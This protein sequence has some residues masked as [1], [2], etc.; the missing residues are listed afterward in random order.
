M[1]KL[2]KALLKYIVL[3]TPKLTP[4]EPFVHGSSSSHA[5]A[6][7]VRSLTAEEL[8]QVLGAREILVQTRNLEELS[9]ALAEINRI[10][11]NNP[12]SPFLPGLRKLSTLGKNDA[13]LYRWNEFYNRDSKESCSLKPEVLSDPK[14]L[15]ELLIVSRY[16]YTK[17]LCDVH[18]GSHLC[19]AY[20][21]Y[22]NVKGGLYQSYSNIGILSD[23]LSVISEG[24]KLK[25]R[26]EELKQK[27]LEKSLKKKEEE[28]AIEYARTVIEQAFSGLFNG[29][30]II[31]EAKM[32]R[33]ASTLLGRWILDLRSSNLETVEPSGVFKMTNL[34]LGEVWFCIV[35]DK[36]S[37]AY[38]HI[39]SFSKAE[40]GRYLYK[41]MTKN[42]MFTPQGVVVKF[43][44]DREKV[45]TNYTFGANDFRLQSDE[46][47]QLLPGKHGGV[48]TPFMLMKSTG[49]S[50]PIATDINSTSSIGNFTIVGKKEVLVGS[51]EV[52]VEGEFVLL[53]EEQCFNTLIIGNAVFV[54]KDGRDFTYTQPDGVEFYINIP[55]QD[56]GIKFASKSSFKDYR[57]GIEARF[58]YSQITQSAQM[59]IRLTAYDVTVLRDEDAEYDLSFYHVLEMIYND[60]N[61]GINIVTVDK[62]FNFEEYFALFIKNNPAQAEAISASLQDLCDISKCYFELLFQNQ[63]DKYPWLLSSNTPE[64]EFKISNINSN[65]SLLFNANN[66][67]AYFSIE[68]GRLVLNVLN[69][70]GEAR[71]LV[72]DS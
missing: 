63:D 17:F 67:Q 55:N 39:H 68:G 5:E 15:A 43:F 21:N 34:L 13:F 3:V 32:I 22:F 47:Y 11:A 71:K 46:D 61:E 58:S 62:L 27:E 53:K 65:G 33:I 16:E 64:I 10:L 37:S 41:D 24:R 18:L 57:E 23:L 66:L 70:N 45:F 36:A 51:T 14:K 49:L 72:F 25:K 1:K 2:S 28:L 20:G 8:K 42:I 4:G 54:C 44:E 48:E 35:K 19:E 26:E 52:P 56:A 50:M 31:A 9:K 6:A 69:S 59:T 12:K 30:I 38:S 40:G 29:S 7:T 60:S